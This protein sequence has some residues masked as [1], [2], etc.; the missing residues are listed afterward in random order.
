MN[1]FKA[2]YG[3][4]AGYR[5]EYPDEVDDSFTNFIHYWITTTLSTEIVDKHLSDEFC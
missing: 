3:V 5:F 1:G 2:V 4:K